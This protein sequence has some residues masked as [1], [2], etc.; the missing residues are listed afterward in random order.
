MTI[1]FTDFEQVVEAFPNSE[2]CQ[3]SKMELF[4]ETVNIT[5][6]LNIFTKKFSLDVWQGSECASGGA[7]TRWK[8]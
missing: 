4:A 5:E 8:D 1:V 6:P 7:Y 2:F 3:T